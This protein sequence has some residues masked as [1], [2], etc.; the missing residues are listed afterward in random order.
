MRRS[1]IAALVVLA[2]FV[3]ACGDDGTSSTTVPPT[4]SSPTTAGSSTVPTSLPDDALDALLLDAGE[5]GP[6]WEFGEPINLMDLAM[7]AELCPDVV[8]DAELAR[9]LDGDTGI[10]FQPVD[11]SYRH[12]MEQLNVGDSAQLALDLQAFFDAA[13]TCADAAPT[14]PG[15]SVPTMDELAL[16]ALGDQ[17]QAFTYFGL[18][19][20]DGP[21]WF[22]RTAF[23]RVGQIVV[24]VALTEILDTP[25]QVP[26]T[27]DDEFVALVE[28]AVD[29]VAD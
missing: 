24:S 2:A 21:V 11:D 1:T 5:A 6:G 18:E 17:R 26:T 4:T 28:R 13:A 27:S 29:K 14:T 22:V 10:Q 8:L 7:S 9:R 19:S 23:V 16:P 25:E 3:G 12:L 15:T 20:T